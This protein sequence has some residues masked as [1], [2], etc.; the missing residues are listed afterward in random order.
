MRITGLIVLSAMALVCGS[1]VARPTSRIEVDHARLS[2]T[3]RFDSGRQTLRFLL[4]ESAGVILTYRLTAPS[5][6]DIRASA[7]LPGVT[8]PLWIGTTTPFGPNGWCTEAGERITCKVSEEWCPMPEGTW[9]F[10]VEKVAGPAGVV[11]LWFRVG[12]PPRQA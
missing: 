12:A 11:R 9:R 2:A 8:V 6:A 5:G 10:R 4:R 3:L 1:A 7:R